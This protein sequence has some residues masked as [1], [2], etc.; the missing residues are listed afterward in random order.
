MA[1]DGNGT[2]FLNHGCNPNV[3]A[4]DEGH[5]II[6]LAKQN[7]LPGQELLLDYYLQAEGENAEAEH[8]C[9]CGSTLCR[10][11]MVLR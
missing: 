10:G 9:R 7:I 11:T 2:R 1:Q 5:R 3:E 8:P 4:I 6:L